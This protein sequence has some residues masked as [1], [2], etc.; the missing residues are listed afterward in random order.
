[1]RHF[2]TIINTCSG[3]CVCVCNIK[4]WKRKVASEPAAAGRCLNMSARVRILHQPSKL[5]IVG[6]V[7]AFPCASAYPDNTHRNVSN[8]RLPTGSLQALGVNEQRL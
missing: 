4:K 1:M 3:V 6:K 2:A 5:S 7:H 8:H